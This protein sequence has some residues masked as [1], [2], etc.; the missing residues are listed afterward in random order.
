MIGLGD[1]GRTFAGKMKA[2]GCY[3]I[4]IR[5][6]VSEKMVAGDVAADEVHGLEDLDRLLPR[7]DVVALSLP[8]NAS[9]FHV[10]NRER[11]G[12]LKPN[13]IVLN[14]G[15]GTAIDTDALSDALYA[16]KITGA[17]LDV[18]D[19]EPLPA[20]HPLWSAPGALITPH[21]SAATPC[22]RRW[23]RSAIFLRR[24]WS[25]FGKGS[26]CGMWWIWGRGYCL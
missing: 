5:R 11:I 20:D 19:P 25:A 10:L 23:P 9:T 22:L 8:G 4:G 13:A 1:I 18:T 26:H 16:G 17:A 2:L 7:A 3:T 15:R 24:T 12:L 14:V 21:I 6:R